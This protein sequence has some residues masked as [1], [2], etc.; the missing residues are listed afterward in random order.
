VS[1]TAGELARTESVEQI[2]EKPAI[3]DLL[4]FTDRRLNLDALTRWLTEVGFQL[5]SHMY[6]NF[7]YLKMGKSVA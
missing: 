7:R 4:A 2:I 6:G 3:K 1:G 5:S